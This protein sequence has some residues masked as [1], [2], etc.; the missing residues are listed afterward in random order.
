MPNNPELV[1]SPRQRGWLHSHLLPL[2]AA[3]FIVL[4]GLSGSYDLAFSDW[5]RSWT[6]DARRPVD[7]LVG[8]VRVF[9]KGEVAIALALIVGALGW[10]KQALQILVAL[11]VVSILVTA[12]K[13]GVMRER[14]NHSHGYSFPSGDAAT[15]AALVGPLIGRSWRL[16]PIMIGLMLGVCYGRIH[17]GYHYPSDVFAGCAT[18]I[19]A[20]I[21]SAWLVARLSKRAPRLPPARAWLACALAWIVAT[22]TVQ[23]WARGHHQPSAGGDMDAFLCV[24]GP[25][26]ALALAVRWSAIARLRSGLGL[27]SWTAPLLIGAATLVTLLWL[28]T[29]S[30]LWD[31]DEPRFARASVEMA[32]SGDYIV[33]TYNGEERLHKP[34]GIYWLMSSSLRAFGETELAAR[35]PAVLAALAIGWLTWWI[36]RR[37]TSTAVGSWAA[38]IVVT[39]PL[40]VVCGSAATTDG[41]LVMF[42]TSAMALFAHQITSMNAGSGSSRSGMLI[43]FGSAV[44]CALLVKG[45][46]GAVP[47]L[48]VVATGFLSWGKPVFT[49]RFTVGFWI[50]FAGAMALA[51]DL[52]LAW[53]IPAFE[54]TD[55]RY[56][57]EGIGRH[58]IGRSLSPMESHGG[59][60]WKSIPY[61][62]PVVIAAFFPWIGLLPGAL[63]ALIAGRLGHETRAFLLAWMVPTFVVMSCVATKLPHY[64]L[65]IFPALALTV[66][67]L[68]AAARDGKL[69][70]RDWRWLRVGTWLMVTMAVVLVVALLAAPWLRLIPLEALP[71]KVAKGLSTLPP[72]PNLLAPLAGIALVIAT[73]AVLAGRAIAHRRLDRAGVAMGI[74]MALFVLAAGLDAM[75]R[76]EELKP[77]KPLALA[78]RAA[79]PATV[80]VSVV[81]YDEASLHFY[82]GRGPVTAIGAGEA[83]VAWTMSPGPGVLVLTR[84]AFE[85]LGRLDGV[86]L[87]SANDSFQITDRAAGSR[88]LRVIG[89]QAGLNI[90][91]GKW[92][93]LIAVAKD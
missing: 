49:E 1:P 35:L 68:M 70:P 4:A 38:A 72:L 32:A 18:G 78:I 51:L 39:S 92:C 71:A 29:R 80:P 62:V 60:F 26:L 11:A 58:V 82:L 61:Y 83:T 19:F 79:T 64:I 25:P 41:V 7:E 12:V 67:L 85:A 87:S 55:G 23:A 20:A 27:R 9:G 21:I 86:T 40:L 56:F 34:A 91:N 52:F 10:R 90:A 13:H 48:A 16:A 6:S 31:R 53:G 14:P 42:I 46:L 28:S 75:P 15:V 37:L 22:L 47:G 36:G 3:C 43:L 66:A 54:R 33:P 76:F 57:S 45:P 59:A 65:P 30:S 74:G 2:I 88:S 5:A 73:I 24:F 89:A 93:D 44:G 17:Q 84:E 50:R 77:S 69:S 8:M 63:S 81:D